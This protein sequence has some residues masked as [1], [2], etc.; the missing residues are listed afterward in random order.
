MNT[1]AQARKVLNGLGILVA[2]LLYFG[3]MIMPVSVL[4][5]LV[6]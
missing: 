4:V 6:K 5:G 2:L 3:F 1:S